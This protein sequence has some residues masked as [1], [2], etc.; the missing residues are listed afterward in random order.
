ML[1]LLSTSDFI[2]LANNTF[3][4]FANNFKTVN[5][6][7]EIN[8]HNWNKIFYSSDEKESISEQDIIDFMCIK[9]YPC[10]YN[11]S[12]FK[13]D[14]GVKYSSGQYTILV[15]NKKYHEYTN[16]YDIPFSEII[17][18]VYDK[19][20]HYISSKTVGKRGNM[21]M[22]N[23]I[24]VNKNE[25]TVKLIKFL[26]DLDDIDKS[27]NTIV[28]LKTFKIDS[29]GEFI[30]NIITEKPG[31]VIWDNLINRRKLLE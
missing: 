13:Y 21:W 16:E 27:I 15:V 10:E 30:E 2:I 23:L 22:S 12:K 14:Y 31:I 24:I 29:S 1:I 9:E 4:T 6:P 5:A 26:E 18:L 17:F 8:E 11:K 28:Y 20:G 7:F 3:Q 19:N 25:I